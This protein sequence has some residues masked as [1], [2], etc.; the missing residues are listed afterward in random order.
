MII[1]RIQVIKNRFDSRETNKR[2]RSL[3]EAKM[4]PLRKK[5][6]IS[7]PSCF[8]ENSQALFVVWLR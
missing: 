5:A 2:E 3:S 6:E 1:Y 7:N 4:E 8:G